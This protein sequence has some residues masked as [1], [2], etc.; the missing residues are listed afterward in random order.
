MG[1]L[2]R[3]DYWD[4]ADT[5]Y[6]VAFI[7]RPT[8][9][10]DKIKEKIQRSLARCS[11]P[12]RSKNPSAESASI[13]KPE[14]RLARAMNGVTGSKIGPRREMLNDGEVPVASVQVNAEAMKAASSFVGS[15]FALPLHTAYINTGMI[16]GSQTE[17]RPRR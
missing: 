7:T 15:N 16:M 5:F 10:P 8:A 6:V 4:N 3:E 1:E 13:R 17:T 11:L 14:D 2:I 9:H 12:H